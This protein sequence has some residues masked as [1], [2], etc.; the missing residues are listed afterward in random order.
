M[1]GVAIDFETT[2]LDTNNDKIIEVGFTAFRAEGGRELSILSSDSFFVKHPG[3]EVPPIITEITGITQ[4]DIDSFGHPPEEIYRVYDLLKPDFFIA[5]NKKFD[6][7]MWNSEMKR[8]GR[9][10]NVP[11]LCTIEDFEHPS[12]ISCRKLSHMALDYGVAVDP[13][14]L[15]R[16]SAD[17]EL[18]V[19]ILKEIKC[20]YDQ[21]LS[22][23]TKPKITVKAIIPAPWTDNNKGMNACKSNGYHWSATKKAWLKTIIEENYS[24]ERERLGYDIAQI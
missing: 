15:H 14:T 23:L 20:D 17:T 11:W 3:V 22:D 5:H 7:S 6:E 13:S 18:L 1:I 24:Q 4:A 21:K 16:A 2:G 12:K 8:Q 19:S 10:V 9:V